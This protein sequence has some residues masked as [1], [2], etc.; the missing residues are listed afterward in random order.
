MA[1]SVI[2]GVVPGAFHRT[3]VARY[4]RGAGAGG[5]TVSVVTHAVATATPTARTTIT[6]RRRSALRY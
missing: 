6:H 2:E 3:A 4:W 5:A 1:S